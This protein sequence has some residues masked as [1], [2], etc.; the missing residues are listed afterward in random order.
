M[1]Q[2]IYSISALSIAVVFAVSMERSSNSG[3]QA[4]YTNEVLTQLVTVGRDVVDDIARKDLPFDEKTDPNRI[5]QPATYPYVLSPD[6]LTPESGFGGC[7]DFD[8]CLD[9]DDFDGMTLEGTR[10]GLHYTASIDVHYVPLDDPNGT[11][12]GNTWAKEIT[13]HVESTSI[14]FNGE[15]VS[16]SYSRV[17]TYPRI[18]NYTY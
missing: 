10:N 15:P 16:T 17:I 9:V 14:L 8:A 5:P 11:P 3:D 12:S 2:L 6:N 1:T 18:T 13:V 4:I 7:V